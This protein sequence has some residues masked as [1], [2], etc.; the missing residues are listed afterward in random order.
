MSDEAMRAA[1]SRVRKRCRE[2]VREQIAQTVA[3]IPEVED[4]YRALLA[5]LRS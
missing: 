1:I 3:S 2:L 4:G 5:A